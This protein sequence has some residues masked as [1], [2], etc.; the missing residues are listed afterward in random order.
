MES[1]THSKKNICKFTRPFCPSTQ[2]DDELWHRTAEALANLAEA[3]TNDHTAVAI[4]STVNTDL[5]QQV[6]N[7]TK[8]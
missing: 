3:T 2:G 4:L 5:T 7:L 6:V 1:P 8:Q